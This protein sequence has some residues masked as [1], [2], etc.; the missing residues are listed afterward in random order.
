MTEGL[1]EGDIIRTFICY[2]TKALLSI[3]CKT[4]VKMLANTLFLGRR[5]FDRF[6]HSSG[7]KARYFNR[8][9][10]IICSQYYAYRYVEEFWCQ[11]INNQ[12]QPNRKIDCADLGASLISTDRSIWCLVGT[13]DWSGA[14]VFATSNRH[15]ACRCGSGWQNPPASLAVIWFL[16]W[17]LIGRSSRLYRHRLVFIV[18]HYF[19]MP[20]DFCAVAERRQYDYWRLPYPGWIDQQLC[21]GRRC[22]DF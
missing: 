13:K 14:P 1:D 7:H 6:W 3:W 5:L 8:P 20:T 16:S 15:G 21:L 18:T 10:L 22:G 17:V 9:A 4:I 2:L 12:C 19:G 11:I